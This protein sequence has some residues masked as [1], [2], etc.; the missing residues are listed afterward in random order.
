MRR[1]HHFLVSF[2][3]DHKP[4]RA[5]INQAHNTIS[6]AMAMQSKPPGSGSY[7]NPAVAAAA[8]SSTTPAQINLSQPAYARRTLQ[9]KFAGTSTVEAHPAPPVYR[10]Q[11]ATQ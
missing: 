4:I 2:N 5:R 11:S 8:R 1:Q 10:P 9:P 6:R 3:L 7:V